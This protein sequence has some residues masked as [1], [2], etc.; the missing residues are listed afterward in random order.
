[1]DKEMELNLEDLENVV[2]GY[3]KQ[4][5]GSSTYPYDREA[6]CSVCSVLSWWN[7]AEQDLKCCPKCGG[8]WAYIRTGAF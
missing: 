4:P 1:M 5:E 6:K 3:E 8:H 2:G 7:S